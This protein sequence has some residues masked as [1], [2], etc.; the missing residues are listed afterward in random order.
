MYLLHSLLFPLCDESISVHFTVFTINVNL[1]SVLLNYCHCLNSVFRE[2]SF[3]KEQTN[4]DNESLISPHSHSIVFSSH[5]PLMLVSGRRFWS[6]T[7]LLRFS[8]ESSKFL[9]VIIVLVSSLQFIISLEN[10]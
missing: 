4:Q 1:L 9:F 6:K 8:A 2:E 3:L 5:G 7:K 10:N